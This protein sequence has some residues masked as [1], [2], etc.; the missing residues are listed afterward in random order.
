MIAKKKVRILS[1]VGARPN[2]M[3]IAPLISEL[4]KC[5]DIEPVLLH[6]GQHYD[7]RMSKVFFEDLAIPKPDIYLGVGSGSHAEQTASVMVKLE[8][9]LLKVKPD[10]VVV[11]GDV[12]STMAAA[13]T[14]SKMAI[15]V[16][17]VEA[18]LR[19]FDRTMPEEI[20][21]I[22]TDSLSDYLFAPSS[23]AVANL[24]NE[25]C[26]D[27]DVF[28]VGNIMI[29]TLF[30]QK[31]RASKSAIL[32]KLNLKDKEYATLTLHRPHN[33]DNK[34]ALTRILVALEEVQKDIRIVFPAHLRTR[35][36]IWRFGLAGRLK[37]MKNLIVTMPMG[38][39]DFLKLL[40]ESR[41][42][43]TDSGGI[44]EETTA[45]GIP[46]ITLRD[47]TERPMTI[48]IGTNMLTGN[49][50]QKILNAAKNIL[51]FGGKAG[52]MPEFWDGKT[53]AR[54]VKVIRERLA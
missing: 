23:D 47:N 32:K 8:K 22:V 37:G 33:V 9:A 3:K 48:T 14:A 44:Q 24:K 5:K 26:A 43:L 11:V 18:G 54:I 31:D 2:M 16:A 45:L 21:R 52:R 46:C 50:T 30:Q 38:Y 34:A 19:S 12:N 20:N 28:L 39:L 10:L 17:H 15:P 6:T 27:E 40:C 13:I 35:K 7:R 1:I 25:G 53:S 36:M 51:K 49:N 41:L 29:D 4:R 42:V